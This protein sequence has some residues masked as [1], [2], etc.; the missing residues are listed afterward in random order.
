MF[1]GSRPVRRREAQFPVYLLRAGRIEAV[2]C[3]CC[4]VSI[5]MIMAQKRMTD[6]FGGPKS[7]KSC[8][9]EDE[10][11]NLLSSSSEEEEIE[12]VEVRGGSHGLWEILTPAEA[13]SSRLSQGRVSRL[14]LQRVPCL[15]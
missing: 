14:H 13:L 3:H 7:K 11:V 9:V 15:V 8:A 4:F 12:P 5:Y 1:T 2:S 10:S 6:F